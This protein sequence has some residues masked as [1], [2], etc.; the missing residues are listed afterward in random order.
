MCYMH[1]ACDWCCGHHEVL[2]VAFIF[3]TLKLA[4][5]MVGVTKG[6]IKERFRCWK[7]LQP[8]QNA[9]TRSVNELALMFRRN[10]VYSVSGKY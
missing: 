8:V 2:P 6:D 3:Y 10:L 9:V 5:P 1:E 7:S 4:L